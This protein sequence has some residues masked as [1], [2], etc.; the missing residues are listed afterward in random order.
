MN[1]GTES[2]T[3]SLEA[4]REEIDLLDAQLLRLL[5]QRAAVACRIGALKVAASLPAYDGRRERQ[6]L[7][8]IRAENPGPF[9]SESVARV[10]R[11]II[12]E[13]RKIGKQAMQQELANQDQ[14]APK[15]RRNG[16]QHG[17]RRV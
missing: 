9:S 6:V 17:G 2:N 4:W 11:R 1:Q 8:R 16:Y 5:N 7:A 12:V 15:E 3:K 10:F 13:T 14:R